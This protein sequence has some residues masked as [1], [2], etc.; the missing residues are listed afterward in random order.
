MDHLSLI[1]HIVSVD[2]NTIEDNEP[3]S[4]T[5]E[6]PLGISN[7]VIGLGISLA[8]LQCAHAG[9][10]FD[11]IKKRGYVQCGVTTDLPGFAYTDSK[12]NWQGIDVDTCRSIAAAVFGDKNKSK[13]VPLT[14]QA[15]FT[16]LQSGEVDV[17]TR[18]TTQ[19]LTRDTTLGLI[20]AGVNY[21]DAQGLMVKSSLGVKSAKELNGATICVLPGTTTELNLAD[22]FRGNGIDFKPVVLDKFDEALRAFSAGRCDAVTADK[23]MLAATRTG[24]GGETALTILPESLSKEPLG[25]MVRQGD[26]QW[27]NI[28]RWVLNAL[29]ETEEYGITQANV[30][31]MTKSANPNVQ[32]I[33][34]VTPGMGK[35]LGIDDKWAYNIV[36]QLGNYGEIYE[37]TLGARSALKLDRGIN[38]LYTHGGVMYGWPVR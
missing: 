29:L 1:R 12:S 20:G 6:T 11:A 31:E 10:S 28:V 32:R 22:W 4:I 36:K 3:A 21:Y 16:A 17:L 24:M 26:E 2:A 9:A 7:I 37:R 35:N 33:L 19:T 18:N 8:C 25:P 34:G 27:F 23:S 38:A 15:R 14:T 5:R 13:I 30:D